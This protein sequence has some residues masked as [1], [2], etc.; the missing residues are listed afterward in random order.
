MYTILRTQISNSTIDSIRVIALEES[1]E[2]IEKR[3]I[4]LFSKEKEDMKDGENDE[5]VEKYSLIEKN[6]KKALI[7]CSSY[8][9]ELETTEIEEV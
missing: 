9:V 8:S 7:E 1:V 4:N 6:N 2:Q 5:L 3:L